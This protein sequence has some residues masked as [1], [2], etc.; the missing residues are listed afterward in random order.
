MMGPTA[1]ETLGD[2]TVLV[3]AVTADGEPAGHVVARWEQRRRFIGYRL[4]REPFGRTRRAGHLGPLRRAGR[5]DVR[6]VRDGPL[7]GAAGREP[8]RCRRARAGRVRAPVGQQTERLRQG[9]PRLRV[10]GGQRQLAV[11]GQPERLELEGEVAHQRVP[12]PLHAA[13]IT[14]FA[15][16]RVA[17][18][19]GITCMK[20]VLLQSSKSVERDHGEVRTA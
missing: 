13:S 1:A 7:M 11:V 8:V 4:G 12:Q 6:A 16:V 15:S 19:S 10:I 5:A 17:T 3:Q 14:C 9:A 20:I 18:H 2:G